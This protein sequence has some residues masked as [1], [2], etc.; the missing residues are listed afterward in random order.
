MSKLKNIFQVVFQ[1]VLD[2]AKELKSSGDTIHQVYGELSISLERLLTT[3]IIKTE[4]ADGSKRIE[5]TEW[6]LDGKERLEFV[7]DI[8]LVE[9]EKLLDKVYKNQQESRSLILWVVLIIASVV[10]ISTLFWGTGTTLIEY[11]LFK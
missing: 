8:Y 2:T 5:E 3:K 11:C 10:V 9:G 6:V 7:K 4:G 1:A